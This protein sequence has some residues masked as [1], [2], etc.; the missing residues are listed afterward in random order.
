MAGITLQQA[1][2]QLE[3]W[4]EASREV[5]TSQSYRI[6][7]RWLTRADLGDIQKQIQYWQSQVSQLSR[8]GRNRVYRT[9]PRDL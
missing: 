1:Q 8:R 6:G 5:A 9:V 3:I 7:T 4:L 2:E